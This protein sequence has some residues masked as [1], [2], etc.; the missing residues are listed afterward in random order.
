M[1]LRQRR[2][3]GSAALVPMMVLLTVALSLTSCGSS[4]PEAGNAATSEDARSTEIAGAQR[5]PAPDVS[6][7]ALP[8]V[9]ATGNETPYPFVADADGLMLVYFGYTHCPD[10]CPTTLADVRTALRQLG[11][12]A[13][14]VQVAMA[15]ID[16]DHDTGEILS[17]YVTSFVDDAVALRTTNDEELAAAAEEFG[18]TYS[19]TANEDGDIEVVHSGS[20]YAVDDTG[21]L[22]VTWSFGTPASDMANDMRL[23]FAGAA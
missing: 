1:T 15:T 6:S 11:D 14:R 3:P 12:D 10:V 18:V 9:D 20:L 22:V 13:A 16:P 4:D 19:V 2:T 7:L 5:V 17:P 23:I 21:T 8:E